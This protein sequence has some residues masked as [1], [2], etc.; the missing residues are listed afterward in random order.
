MEGG[1][2]QPST[3]YY[4]P[5]RSPSETFCMLLNKSE[6]HSKFPKCTQM[7]IQEVTFIQEAYIFLCV[8]LY[9]YPWWQENKRGD[10]CLLTRE[11]FHWDQLCD[12]KLWTTSNDYYSCMLWYKPVTSN[13]ILFRMKNILRNPKLIKTVNLIFTNPYLIFSFYTTVVS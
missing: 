7:W 6:R 8:I 2:K 9:D 1:P 5:C 13:I 10:S 11:L 4:H 12:R 3:L